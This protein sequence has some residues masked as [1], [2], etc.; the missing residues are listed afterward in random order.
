[1]RW[2]VD[3]GDSI[4]VG[5]SNAVARALAQRDAFPSGHAMMTLVLIALGFHW[6]IR[7]RFF[8]LAAG[9][10]LILATV[11]LRYHYVIDVLAGAALAVLC[12]RTTREF[13]EKVC[14]EL[15]KLHG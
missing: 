14:Q 12:L 7:A 3:S 2:F 10:L 4:P 5:A 8:I 13:H 1:M 15:H 11:Y 9:A 6:H